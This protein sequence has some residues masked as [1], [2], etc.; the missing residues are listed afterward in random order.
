MFTPEVADGVHRI[1]H[2]HVNCYLVEDDDGVTLVDAGLP[3][4]WPMLLAALEE[5]GRRPDE[6]RALLLTHAHF[7]HVGFARR[8]QQEWELPVYGH[9]ADAW[10]AAH[11]Y[12]YR[13]ERNRFLYPFCHPRSLPLLGR[14]VVA[15][16]LAVQGVRELRPLEVGTPLPVPGRPVVVHTPGH[17]DG[18]CVLGL[19]DRDAVL[20][21]DA[22]VTLDPYTGRRGPQIVAAAATKD[23]AVALDSLDAVAAT[24][25]RTVLPGHGERWTQGAEAAVRHARAVGAH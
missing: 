10:L 17:T 24:G 21:G 25:A 23:T 9:P 2:A 15:G 18:H 6:V 11:P 4:M 8:A 13:P 7:D 14:V 1:T 19:P 16:G 20:S 5:R 12:R 22:I 3:S